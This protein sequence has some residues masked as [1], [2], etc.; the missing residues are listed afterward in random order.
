MFRNK[1][2][3]ST[4]VILGILFSTIDVQGQS[5]SNRDSLFQVW[6]D[7][8]LPD[9]TRMAA[10]VAMISNHYE[11]SILD[12][13]MYYSQ[14][15][16]EKAQQSKNAYYTAC[17]RS[18]MGNSALYMGRYVEAK[19]HHERALAYW[20]E[21]GD[22]EKQ[23][24]SYNALGV[25]NNTFGQ[26]D[27]ALEELEKGMALTLEV[28]DSSGI[29]RYLLNIA[30]IFEAKGELLKSLENNLVALGLSQQHQN[31]RNESI[32]HNNL[33]NNY[34]DLGDVNKAAHHYYECL[35]LYESA[36]NPWGVVSA[37]SNL[38][39]LYINNQSYSKAE[40]YLKEGLKLAKSIDFYEGMAMTYAN[41]GALR[42]AEKDYV[43]AAEAYKECLK[44]VQ[45]NGMLNRVPFVQL[46]LGNTYLKS[47][48]FVEAEKYIDKGLANSQEL[49]F[50]QF[51]LSGM[52]YK[53][54]LL[55]EQGKWQKAESYGIKGYNQSKDIQD[56][57][58]QSD[59]AAQLVIIYKQL[60]RNAEALQMFETKQLLKDSLLNEE[61]TRALIQQEYQYNYER[62]TFQDSLAN[63]ATLEQKNAD[64]RR[65]SLINRF[66][67]AI[68]LI[69][70]VFVGMLVNRYRYI[71]KQRLSIQEAKDRAESE[72]EKA[73][74][75]NAKLL[76][77]DQSK[78][79][80]FT[81]I[82]HEF[83]T[84]LTVISGMTEQIKEEGRVKQLIQRNTRHLLQLI[85]QILDLRKLESGSLPT[86][87]I[88]SD[89]VK[90]LKY[91]LESFHSMAEEKAIQLEFEAVE[92]SIILDYDP[93]K[94][95]RILT[96]LL[97]NAIKFT[98][99]GGQVKLLVT[100]Q[101]DQ[102]KPVYRFSVSDTGVG[103]A[104]EKIP[105]VFDRFYQ[106]DDEVSKTG[107]GT[108]IGLALTK[109]LVDLLSGSIQV[110]SQEGKGT[111]FTVELPYNQQAIFVNDAIEET[112]AIVPISATSSAEMI[113]NKTQFADDNLPSLLIVEDNP[114]VM[115]YLITCLEGDYQLS[116]AYD[117]QDGLEKALELIPDIIIS[118]VMMPRMDGYT[119]CD[120][121]KKEERTSHIP[122]VLLT[123]KA[124][125]D[126]RITGL[127][128]GADAYLAKP[129]DQRE[130]SVQL[131]NL[132]T[133]RQRLHTRYSSLEP[134]SNTED[135][136]VQKEDEF[137][138]KLRE[139]FEARIDDPQFDLN[140][141][142]K[143]MLMSRT[144]LGRKVKALT[145]RTPA[146][147]LRSI[148]LQKARILLLTTT[149]SIKE[150]SYDVGF[151]NQGY[152][153]N[154]YKEEF[155]EYP[156]LTREK[157]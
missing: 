30:A 143:A 64:I 153:S 63:I 12:S 127:E 48:D 94:L 13:A 138:T 18:L 32:G 53:C 97:S 23:A 85:N 141:L 89:V 79:R 71:Q 45:E 115:E 17:G 57:S 2:I 116:F 77:I 9:T 109:E 111:T 43:A 107:E 5:L 41:T 4:C 54:M 36:D 139:T 82:S 49:G 69:V 66:L 129:F 106:V 52:L 132:L 15:L 101:S 131:S 130:L 50:S 93:E 120:T 119:L 108:G 104:P 98:D 60:G 88:Q 22:K 44:I 51:I 149:L 91:I 70:V 29:I 55:I 72:K 100:T 46:E 87:Y 150:I 65:R 144:H 28:K 126:S 123:A 10:M 59:F 74:A 155:G 92:Q 42:D 61:T 121:L 84:P 38:A 40:E 90:Y 14:L 25:L 136:A 147:Y 35:K 151:S 81:N 124:D 103:I 26:F 7:V 117:G 11:A 86:R 75:A 78:S 114:D 133:L 19:E 47:R 56:L 154:S 99:N 156:T 39:L 152:F 33:G 145:G 8:D 6:E 112:A 62:K 113:K 16:F 125:I 95:L 122:I 134:L 140:A 67:W 137:I 157:Q 146:I 102:A 68:L 73:E 142:S 135:I 31:L 37:Y 24:D 21:I 96:N 118:D 3:Y 1:Y 128:H 27:L 110:D 34:K 105:Y 80:F 148:R 83:R 58:L 76:E 20:L